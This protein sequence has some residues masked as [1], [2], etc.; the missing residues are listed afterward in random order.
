MDIAVFT[1]SDRVFKQLGNMGSDC[2]VIRINTIKD[3]EDHI[4]DGVLEVGCW[5]SGGGMETDDRKEA[6]D[7]LKAQQSDLF[8]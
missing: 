5:K 7:L 6:Y 2:Y 4:F 3:I 8:E 1:A